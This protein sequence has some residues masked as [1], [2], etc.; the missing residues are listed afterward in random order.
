[1]IVLGLDPGPFKTGF[2][3]ARREPRSTG[4]V[5]L[6]RGGWTASPGPGPTPSGAAFEAFDEERGREDAVVAIE[7]PTALHPRV[8]ASPANM[9][10]RSKQLL[11]TARVA[12]RLA[13]MARLRGLVLAELRATDWRRAFCGKGNASDADIARACRVNVTG[14]ALRS[15]AHM[16]D[17]LG[18]AC[19]VLWN[20]ELAT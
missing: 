9:I 6:L 1:M 13:N 15:N 14:L 17:A 8:G 10:A 18:L 11:A 2:A 7:V 19:V 20:P 12:E 5:L 16:R 3:I 4:R